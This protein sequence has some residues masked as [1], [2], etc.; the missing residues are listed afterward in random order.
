M[1]SN[2]ER[3]PV[4]T[5]SA[6]AICRWKGTGAKVFDQSWPGFTR[7]SCKWSVRK[8]RR[9]GQYAFPEGPQDPGVD[10]RVHPEIVG[11]QDD[12]RGVGR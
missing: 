12:C 1:N 10:R 4:I 3:K 5:N 11:M 8:N 2:I 9:A 6:P 7:L